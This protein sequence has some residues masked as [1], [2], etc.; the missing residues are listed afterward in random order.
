MATITP[1]IAGARWGPRNWQ[2]FDYMAHSIRDKDGNPCL[3]LRHG[4][5]GLSGNLTDNWQGSSNFNQVLVQLLAA[6]DV[7]WDIIS[8][9]TCQRRITDGSPTIRR[10]IKAG[11][12]EGAADLQRAIVA[13]K[14][15]AH[16][17]GN[18]SSYKIDPSKIAVGGFSFGGTQAA[19]SQIRAPI[20][21]NGSQR[22][23]RQA[24]WE[25]SGFD[26]RTLGTVLVSAQVDC[27]KISGVNYLSPTQLSGWALT[28]LTDITEF[29]LVSD[30]VKDAMSLR[31]YFD[32]GDTQ[33]YR[34]WFVTQEVTA[35]PHTYPL[36][37]P[38][39]SIQVTDL[40]ETMKKAG[41]R[42]GKDFGWDLWSTAGHAMDAV[43]ANKVVKFL[44]GLLPV[45]IAT[46]GKVG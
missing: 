6:T 24:Q 1:T 42:D 38:H 2:I 18:N 9:Q 30:F 35:G 27:R 39:D 12:L 31:A 36:A 11:L 29:D 20:V 5:A 25:T 21:G 43:A 22:T 33:F 40:V 32:N 7:H 26:S 4:G 19:L 15:Q 45:P 44:N 16:R 28:N 46:G 8:V 3:I 41:L 37:D 10:A 34:P 13:I 17:V 14:G 23:G